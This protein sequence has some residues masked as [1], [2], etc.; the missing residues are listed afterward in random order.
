MVKRNVQVEMLENIVIPPLM[1]Y[2]SL[3]R[4]TRETLR[5]RLDERKRELHTERNLERTKSRYTANHQNVVSN[6]KNT[7]III[8]F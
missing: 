6:S 2:R 3:C 1:A 8:D 5:A 4:G 7:A